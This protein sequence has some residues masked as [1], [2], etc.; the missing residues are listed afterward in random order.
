MKTTFFRLL[1]VVITLLSFSF[2]L[3]SIVSLGQRKAFASEAGQRPVTAFQFEVDGEK[4]IPSAAITQE[5]MSLNPASFSNDL[6][7][8]LSTK[9]N[10]SNIYVS[11]NITSERR[12][13]SVVANRLTRVG[14]VG[15]RGL[16]PSQI[17]QFRM[18]L[19]VKVGIPWV[20][21]ESERD[22]ESIR[23][24]LQERGYLSA[25]VGP[26]EVSTAIS[27]ELKVIYPVE[28]NAPCRVS[29]VITEPDV[30]IFDYFSTPLELGSLCDRVAIN[31]ILERQRSSLVSDGFLNA[32][33]SMIRLVVSEDRLT[34]R[35]SLKY[36]RGPRTRLELV[37]RQTGVVSDVFSEY[38]ES[39]SAFDV[40]TF[41]DDE[42][43]SLVRRIFV[44][45]GYATAQV[46]GPSRLTDI[47]GDSVLRFFLQ[48]GPLITLS[49]IDFSGEIPFKKE[50]LVSEM[51]LSPGVF[52][53]AIPFVEE[54][55][56]RY[57]DRLLEI[58]YEEGFSEAT[59]ADPVATYSP[60][61]RS[62]RLL[63]QAN[64]GIRSVL[65]D[66][67]ILGR[68]FDFSLT[69]SFEER[70]L[71]PGQ[72]VNAGRMRDLESDVR[73]ELMKAG[74]AYA[75]AEV[76]TKKLDPIGKI[77]PIRVIV[78]LDPGPLVRIGRVFAD[79]DLFGKKE[80]VI[81]ES[82]L[83]Q[84]EVF[85]PDVLE[86]AR[87]R[88][89]KHDLFDSVVIEPLT[90]ESIERREHSLDLIIRAQAKRSY[91]LGLSPS[92]GTRNGYR[93]SIDYAKNN[94]TRDGL[95][96][97]SVVSFSQEKLQ[98]SVLTNQRILGRKLTLGLSE[99]MLK[100][101][102]VVTPFDWNVLSGFEVSAQSLTD[103]YFE[104]VETGLFW[105]PLFLEKT[106]SVQAKFA[107]EWSKAI[108]VSRQTLDA[109]DR[110]T[111]KIHEF[112]FGLSLDTR[113]NP[114]WPTSGGTFDFSSNHARFGLGSDVRF[115]R[116]SADFGY[117]FPVWKRI[118]G[119][120]SSGGLKVTD[121][122]N[123]RSEA[124]TAPGSRRAT[125]AGR[126]LVRGFPEASSSLTPGPLVWLNLTPPADNPELLCAPTLRTIGAT[127][128][129]YAKSE[130]RFR[131]PLFGDSLGFAGF[132]DSGA[133]FFTTSELASLQSRLS[134]DEGVLDSGSIDSCALNSAQV[135]SDGAVDFNDWSALRRYIKNSYISAGFSARY[136][137]STFASLNFDVGF[138][139]R[140][141]NQQEQCI[142]ASQ[143][144]DSRQAPKCV[145]R[146]STSTLF[147]VIPL[148]GA[149]H[150]GIG[151]NF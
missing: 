91:T 101:G 65:R 11:E 93:F 32:E 18:G 49:S 34:A 39:V 27:G 64:S 118:S 4:W 142:N 75:T 84:G 89:L 115:D 53:G 40:L 61:G 108:G 19:K 116:Y 109:L 90:I 35:V 121:V 143:V 131:S 88:L 47:N 14:E 50:D 48:T 5:I 74:Y 80:R 22:R 129:I 12:V 98:R 145:S 102:N 125:L 2:V 52:S 78:D 38:R 63:F 44:K 141:P 86:A 30:S 85:S 151:A 87:M 95:R 147:G 31:E 103:R 59:V 17:Q 97:T 133:A 62:V 57:R 6:I 58:F 23:A 15:F 8:I 36:L 56:P 128:V 114:E 7:K 111:V 55:L 77:Q 107:H 135:I 71:Q 83:V 1:K 28:L 132:V 9:L 73:L 68:P 148:P 122:L 105:R 96:F 3:S 117:F 106:W 26:A 13:I 126:S 67:S 60:D 29:E 24:K 146:R 99:P 46:S 139:L 123:S 25:V 82:G 140:E 124:F 127:N 45:R 92:F 70:I 21:D 119:A 112:V 41:S 42:L 51:E 150:V 69:K 137:I 134:G 120:I 37:N 43:R 113:V 72:P 136:I 144:A 110:P 104:T 79:G 76:R 130:L 16:L 33:L 81:A 10:L 94:L 20:P 54:D 66:V 149:Y 138:P 100:L